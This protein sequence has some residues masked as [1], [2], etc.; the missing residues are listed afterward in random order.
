MAGQIGVKVNPDVFGM[1]FRVGAKITGQEGFA[2]R[3]TEKGIP[4]NMLLVDFGFIRKE[5]QFFFVFREKGDQNPG[6]VQW[7]APVYEKE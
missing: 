5:G 6:A 7:Q 4:G 3:L 2:A 1:L